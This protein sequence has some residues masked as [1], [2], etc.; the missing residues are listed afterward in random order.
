M[1]PCILDQGSG[2]STDSSLSH[3]YYFFLYP[4]EWSRFINHENLILLILGCIWKTKLLKVSRYHAIVD[5]IEIDKGLTKTINGSI[6]V[7]Y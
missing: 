3:G 6:F 7:F 5:F 4:L 1:G 2:F